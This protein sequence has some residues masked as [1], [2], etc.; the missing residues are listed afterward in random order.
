MSARFRLTH[1]KLIHILGYYS[2]PS[3]KG[4]ATVAIFPLVHTPNPVLRR[5]TKLVKTVDRRIRKLVDD[6]IETMHDAHGVGLAANQVG[7]SLRVA[8]IQLP[9]EETAMILINPKVMR[10][11]GERELEG[12]GCLSVPGFR[13]TVKRAEQIRVRALDIDGK[14]FR[15]RATDDLLAQA[16]EHETDHLDGVL[17][18]DHLVSEDSIWEEPPP[19]PE[20]EDGEGHD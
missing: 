9:E 3:D 15:V 18:L 4:L 8:V 20:A 10:L 1:P 16:L 19:E 7:I 6:M 11:E 13:G 14:E 17:Y 2:E 5:K 12:E